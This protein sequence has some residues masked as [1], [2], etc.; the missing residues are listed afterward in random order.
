MNTL[1]DEKSV[2]LSEA[3]MAMLKRHDQKPLGEKGVYLAY[4]LPSH[5]EETKAETHRGT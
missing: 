4:K 1:D 3:S 2:C 5:M